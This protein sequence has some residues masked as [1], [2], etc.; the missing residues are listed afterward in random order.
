MKGEEEIASC[1]L[2]FEMWGGP[3]RRSSGAPGCCPAGCVLLA[4]LDQCRVYNV[5]GYGITDEEV[6][7]PCAVR[8]GFPEEVTFCAITWKG[9]GALPSSYMR[10]VTPGP[11]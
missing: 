10:N 1:L 4:G 5:D 6:S 7:S 3:A 11:R 8:E 2:E 9:S